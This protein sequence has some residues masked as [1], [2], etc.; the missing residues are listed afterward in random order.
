MAEIVHRVEKNYLE[1]CLVCIV[2]EK[3]SKYRE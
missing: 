2:C 3:E 1:S